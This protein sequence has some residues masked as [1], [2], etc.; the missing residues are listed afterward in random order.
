ML[1]SNFH[2]SHHILECAVNQ[3]IQSKKNNFMYKYLDVYELLLHTYTWYEFY[4]IQDEPVKLKIF[5]FGLLIHANHSHICYQ[6][7]MNPH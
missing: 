7:A 3:T 2:V 5:M 4:D 6:W 1:Q